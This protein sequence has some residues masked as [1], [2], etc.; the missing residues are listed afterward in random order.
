MSLI[1]NLYADPNA[2]QQLKVWACNSRK[3]SDGKYVYTGSNNTWSALFHGIPLGCV[4]A[5]DFDSSRRDS[6]MIEGCTDMYRGSTTWA[7]VYTTGGNCSLFCTGDG[8][9]VSATVNRIGVYT[10]D[11]WNRL[12][13]YGL[14]WFDGGTMP[15]A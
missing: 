4:L 8:N 15:L 14:E 5:I 3:N 1:T 2:L 6:F 11:D 7:G 12:R 13:Q 10:Q 9:G